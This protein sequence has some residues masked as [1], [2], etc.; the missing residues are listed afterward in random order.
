MSL[1][2]NHSKE[3]SEETRTACERLVD[4]GIPLGSQTVLLKGDELGLG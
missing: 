3:I 2:F 1:H 4:A